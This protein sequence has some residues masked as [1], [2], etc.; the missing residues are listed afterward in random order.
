MSK[1]I[2]FDIDNV[3]QVFNVNAKCQ[4]HSLK[5]RLLRN[6]SENRGKQKQE[7]K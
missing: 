1:A 3:N 4:P 7:I 5:M 6:R 2:T